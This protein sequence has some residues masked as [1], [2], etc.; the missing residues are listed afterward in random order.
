MKISSEAKGLEEVRLL[1]RLFLVGVK[2]SFPCKV[3]EKETMQFQVKV[4]KVALNSELC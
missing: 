3:R 4:S 1:K 2:C